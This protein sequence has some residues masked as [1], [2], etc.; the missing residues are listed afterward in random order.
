[1]SNRSTVRLFGAFFAT[2]FV[3]PVFSQEAAP[4]VTRFAAKHVFSEGVGHDRG[5][6]TLEWFL[7]LEQDSEIEMWFGDFRA[8]MFDDAEFGGNLGLGYRHYHADHD[9]I[10]GINAYWDFRD[11]SSLLFNQAGIGLET[12]GQVFDFRLNGYVPTVNDSSQRLPFTFSGHSLME[13]E[14]HALSGFDYEAAVNLPDWGPLQ[15]RVAGGGYFFDSS[16]TDA[17]NGWRARL[18]LA[19]KDSIAASVAVQDDDVFGQTVNFMVEIRRTIEHTSRL[20]RRSM[21]HKFQN[22]EGSGDGQSVMHRLADPVY[23]QSNIVL[24]RTETPVTDNS[25]NSLNFLHVVEGGGGDGT[26]EMPFGSITD[27]MGDPLAPTSIVYTPEGGTFTEP[28][29]TLV[30]GT[31]L[32][33]NGPVQTVTSSLG[34]VQLPFSGAGNDL[35]ALPASIIGDV[36]LADAT[37]LSGFDITGGVSGTGLMTAN[38]NQTAINSALGDALSF[39]NSDDITI[40]RLAISMPAGHGILLNDTAATL[41]DVAI[42]NAGD[43]GIQV[44]NAATDRIVTASNVTITDA[45]NEGVDVNVTGAGDLM[46]AFSNSTVS[47][48]NNAFDVSTTAAGDAF[49]SVDELTLASTSGTGINADGSAGAGTLIIN[50]FSNNTVTNAMAGGVLFNTVTFDSDSMTAGD[51]SVSSG[52]LTVGSSGTRVESIGV[53]LIDVS[54]DWNAGVLSIFNNNDTG[55][56]ANNSV[57]GTPLILASETGSVINSLTGA[58]LELNTITANELTFDSITSTDSTT[59][60][61]GFTTVTGD[62]ISGT[63]TLAD[64]ALAAIRYEAITGANIF[65]PNLGNT[66]IES[67]ISD[68]PADNIEEVGLTDGVLPTYTPLTINFP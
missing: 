59:R 14:Y 50:S 53:S 9:R 55:F 47:S 10:Y 54:G 39:T 29:V 3:A 68:V 22:P 38:V 8:I 24:H 49:V 21:H 40:D 61:L 35:S 60:G 31:R 58:A 19:F 4:W 67:T 42:A 33:S 1:M 30:S 41:S 26:F 48:T 28:V 63:T 7:P 66:V 12:L 15:T 23:R 52:A 18:E 27:A 65:R 17:A 5:L 45:V 32:L 43:D 46:L 11:E 64:S 57:L 13:N 51:Q 44:D 62:L 37:E 56:V 20:A 2:V 25:G 16:N 36:V 34:D 6:T